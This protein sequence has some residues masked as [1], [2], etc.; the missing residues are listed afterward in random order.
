MTTIRIG[1]EASVGYVDSDHSVFL[2]RAQVFTPLRNFGG[3]LGLL[4]RIPK[5][6]SFNRKQSRRVKTTF[7]T[8]LALSVICVRTSIAQNAG[9]VL[10]LRN[11]RINFY[12]TVVGNQNATSLL[13]DGGRNGVLPGESLLV[14]A[15]T[16]A[17]LRSLDLFY[18]LS[19]DD[20]H[21]SWQF[22]VSPGS[23][24]AFPLA[25]QQGSVSISDIDWR[26]TLGNI[27]EQGVLG[28]QILSGNWAVTS[29]GGS[30]VGFQF[31]GT[32]ISSLSDLSFTARLLNSTTIPEPSSVAFAF[33]GML[34]LLSRHFRTTHGKQER[35]LGLTGRN[36]TATRVP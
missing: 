28:V 20:L 14:E 15:R 2:A 30:G 22:D 25:I 16:P 31:T 19:G 9:P 8:L 27:Y 24:P 33:L 12:A 17:S 4:P 35:L 7:K 6:I 23:T 3:L 18:S 36:F 29:F 34:A 21:V 26:D 13:W 5:S 1:S 10:S 32:S 11:D